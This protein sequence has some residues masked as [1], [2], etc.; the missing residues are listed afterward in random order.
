M[1]FYHPEAPGSN[2]S[3]RPWWL[4]PPRQL[5]PYDFQGEVFN[6]TRKQRFLTFKALELLQNSERQASNFCPNVKLV[7][8][9]LR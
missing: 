6:Q 7:G 1:E 3:V 9:I 2:T 8:C 4:T 5:L